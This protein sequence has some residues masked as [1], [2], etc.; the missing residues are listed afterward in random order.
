MKP[1]S[2]VVR[3]VSLCSTFLISSSFRFAKPRASASDTEDRR[4]PQ[5]NRRGKTS[6]LSQR[7]LQFNVSLILLRKRQLYIGSDSSRRFFKRQYSIFLLIKLHLIVHQLYICLIWSKIAP[8]QF[9]RLKRNSP[10]FLLPVICA[11]LSYFMLTFV[12]PHQTINSE[13]W[14]S[15]PHTSSWVS[16]STRPCAQIWQK[17]FAHY[18]I[19]NNVY[20]KINALP[21]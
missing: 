14:G 12:R 3:A 17:L 2:V 6:W 15:V 21:S 10:G 13:K 5:C 18:F 11:G 1:R 16:M 19:E 7:K 20:M 4:I 9:Q 8:E